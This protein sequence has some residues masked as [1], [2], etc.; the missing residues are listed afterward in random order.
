VAPKA[1][2][3]R[4]LLYE[5][6][7]VVES[8]PFVRAVVLNF[9]GGDVVFDAIAALSKTEW[10]T[11]QFE[12]VCVDNGSTDGSIEQ[13][14][15]HFPAVRVHRN[16]RNVGFPGNNAAMNDLDGVDFIALVNSDAFVEPDWLAPLVRRAEESQ[17]IGAVCPKV[18][19][20]G[21]FGEIG[22]RSNGLLGRQGTAVL[23]GVTVNGVDVFNRLHV[24]DGGGRS[25]DRNGIFESLF[26]ECIL[27]FPLPENWS[28]LDAVTVEAVVEARGD[29]EV[30]FES[31]V[32]STLKLEAGDRETLA[33]TVETHGTDVINDVGSWIDSAWLGHERGLYQR[34]E[35]QFDRSI[36]VGTWCGASVLLRSDYLRDVGLFEESFFL[37][38]EDTDL[39][40]RGRTRGWR[41][42]TEPES[43]VRHLHSASTV[44][45]SELASHFI[46]R[47][48]LLLI[49]RHAE[50]QT[51]VHQV[52][53]YLLITASYV[54]YA[55]R[56]AWSLRRR[57]DVLIARRRF[58]A[59]A[60]VL[61]ML[62]EALRASRALN[63]RRLLTASELV[64]QLARGAPNEP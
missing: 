43:V 14:E 21:K 44:E 8:I 48:R 47:N 5:P 57:P 16:G 26:G 61:K 46:E 18:L 28:S 1:P 30:A 58:G 45:G 23:R 6:M 19:F 39:A 20:S 9:N 41:Y 63:K 56:G 27:R 50:W 3:E 32:S 31:S 10:P 4:R 29:C 53:R 11:R 15:F 42:V 7:S 54:R 22:I 52:S 24:V 51:V 35:R 25:A 40:V 33:L 60:A 64:N 12:I 17:G 13:I 36:E 55:F 2:D 49:V 38:Y 59:F 62:P 37:Y 34:D